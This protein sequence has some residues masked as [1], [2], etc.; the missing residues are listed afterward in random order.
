MVKTMTWMFRLFL[1]ATILGGCSLNLYA[2]KEQT[3]YNMEIR[4]K[5]NNRKDDFRTSTR[6]IK[7]LKERISILEKEVG[8]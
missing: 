6:H 3:K 4:G 2:W 8:L 5:T 7:E 1:I